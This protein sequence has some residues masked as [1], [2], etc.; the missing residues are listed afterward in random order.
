MP[1]TP[2]QFREMQVRVSPKDSENTKSGA[3]AGPESDLHD[4]I[5]SELVRRRWFFVRSRMD[6]PTTQ[7]AGVPD[8]ICAAPDGV[9]HWIEV[10]RKGGKLSKEQNITKYVL[11]A[12]G[13]RYATVY[14]FD[15]FLTA[16]KPEAEI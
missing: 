8:F 16:T 11:L 3:F 2:D 4:L 10:K 14:S 15:E 5:S 6:R 12:L 1:I 13:H 9:T 7:Q